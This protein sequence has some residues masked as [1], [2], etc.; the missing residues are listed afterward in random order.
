[1][2]EQWH[3]IWVNSFYQIYCVIEYFLCANREQVKPENRKI[4]RKLKT[5]G[6]GVHFCPV[7]SKVPGPV[8]ATVG[9]L[10]FPRKNTE[11]KGTQSEGKGR[12]AS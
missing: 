2:R 12:E 10:L 9:D 7:G 8:L 4:N 5:G 11:R 6:Q 3:F 1:M